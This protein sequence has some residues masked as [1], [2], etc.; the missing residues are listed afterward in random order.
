MAKNLNRL[1]T[2]EDIHMHNKY[3]KEFDFVNQGNAD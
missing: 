1:F 2:K 3:M